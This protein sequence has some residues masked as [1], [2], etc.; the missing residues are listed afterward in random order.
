MTGA[1]GT[2]KPASGILLG[3]GIE[4]EIHMNNKMG[5]PTAFS[6]IERFAS[7]SKSPNRL[8]VKARPLRGSFAQDG[9]VLFEPELDIQHPK[10][11]R[12]GFGLAHLDWLLVAKSRNPS[13]ALA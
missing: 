1:K 6:C 10:T 5:L 2:A 8:D 7:E 11:S 9:L 13:Q 4:H 12:T 3:V